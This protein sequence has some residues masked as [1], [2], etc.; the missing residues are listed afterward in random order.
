LGTSHRYSN[1][2]DGLRAWASYIVGSN[3][4]P[5]KSGSLDIEFKDAS[6]YRIGTGLNFL[7]LSLNLEYQNIKYDKTILEQFGPFSPEVN[8]DN[9]DL[10]NKSW[11]ASVSFPYNL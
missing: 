7:M 10:R 9:V 6:G 3:F 8:F 11:I 4:N 1:S 2:F 5:E